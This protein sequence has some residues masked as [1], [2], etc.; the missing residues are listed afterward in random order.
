MYLFRRNHGLIALLILFLS[1][2]TGGASTSS[3]PDSPASV[4]N[5]AAALADSN[6]FI[7]FCFAL[8]RSERRPPRSAA[9]RIWQRPWVWHGAPCARA[10]SARVTPVR[11]MPFLRVCVESAEERTAQAA[12]EAR[13][14]WRE[15]A[16]RAALLRRAR[17][18]PPLPPW[19]PLLLLLLGKSSGIRSRRRPPSAD[20]DA[21]RACAPASALPLAA[22]PQDQL[23]A[24][25]SALDALVSA[26][27]P[28]GNP[29]DITVLSAALEDIRSVR[30]LL[31]GLAEFASLSRRR[32]PRTRGLRGRTRTAPGRRRRAWAPPCRRSWRRRAAASGGAP[33]RATT[34]EPEFWAAHADARRVLQPLR[35]WDALWL[36]LAEDTMQPESELLR[37]ASKREER[38]QKREAAGVEAAGEAG[39]GPS[40]PGGGCARRRGGS[41]RGGGGARSGAARR[42]R[43]VA[44]GEPPRGVHARRWV[45][46][47]GI[48]RER[49]ARERL[50]QHGGLPRGRVERAAVC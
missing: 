28:A 10:T 2:S 5:D 39:G 4:I 37:D 15:V 46:A 14:R 48:R 34:R 17:P 23:S 25:E 47:H 30:S 38:A 42:L 19:T 40:A 36:L 18:P 45:E 35:D 26:Q 12:G 44:G 7:P 27:P 50:V 8:C 21:D 49:G 13:R 33:S 22:L 32:R 1:S 41:A 29:A 9:A 3:S 24:D 16:E 6:L 20:A 11:G 31:A 43:R